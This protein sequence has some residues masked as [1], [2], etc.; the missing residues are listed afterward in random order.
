M[1]LYMHRVESTT[2]I[3]TPEIPGFSSAPLSRN[4]S[5][6]VHARSLAT[7]VFA[8]GADH[9]QRTR[10]RIDGPVIPAKLLTG[11]AAGECIDLINGVSKASRRAV[12]GR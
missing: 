9:L 11:H 8:T 2:L 4:E 12:I 3:D 7:P 1:L 5:G 6:K 10:H